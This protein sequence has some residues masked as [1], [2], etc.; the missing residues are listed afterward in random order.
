MTEKEEKL[1]PCNDIPCKDFGKAC[2]DC[3]LN[4]NSVN[5]EEGWED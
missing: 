4:P 3:E 1:G 5:Y 2:E